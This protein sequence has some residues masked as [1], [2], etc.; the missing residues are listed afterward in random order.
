MESNQIPT[1]RVFVDSSVLISAA[2]S[3]RGSAHDLVRLGVDHRATLVIS[4]TV[5]DEVE[6]N[7]TRKGRDRLPLLR[8][9]LETCPFEMC[10]PTAE[11]IAIEAAKVEPK[12]AEIV[13]AAVAGNVQFLVTYDAKHLLARAADIQARNGIVVCV[14]AVP[15]AFLSDPE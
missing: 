4:S 7:V 8:R 2:L 10:E 6:R 9:L 5:L 11:L 1:L 15:I 14:P 13:A 12:D 3:S